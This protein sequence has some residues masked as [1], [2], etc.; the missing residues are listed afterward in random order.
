MKIVVDNKCLQQVKNFKYLGCEISY[1][2]NKRYSTKAIK[3]F[4]N[5]GNSNNTLKATSVQ[6]F[7][8]I[9]VHNA[10]AM[11]TLCMEKKFRHLEKIIKKTDIN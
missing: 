6:K 8:G 2:N 7:S 3:V 9:E 11:P 5:T 10:L 4:S 1:E